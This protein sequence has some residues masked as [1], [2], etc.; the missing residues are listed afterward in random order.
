M[1]EGCQAGGLGQ[2]LQFM[3]EYNAKSP[4]Q[5]RK[6]FNSIVKT[7]YFLYLPIIYLCIKVTRFSSEKQYIRKI[8]K[9]GF[10][11]QWNPTFVYLLYNFCFS[12]TLLCDGA[13]R[14]ECP[15]GRGCD[16]SVP[17]TENSW[18]GF[19]RTSYKLSRNSV[20][21]SFLYFFTFNS[22]WT[23]LNTYWKSIYRLNIGWNWFIKKNIG[24]CNLNQEAY[25]LNAFQVR[26]EPAPR[27]VWSREDGQP[28]ELRAVTD[29][30]QNLHIYSALARSSYQRF[31]PFFW[32]G[33]FKLVLNCASRHFFKASA[34]PAI[35]TLSLNFI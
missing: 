15:R 31:P 18:L 1:V 34:L 8:I 12:E 20:R 33:R 14:R 21:K 28:L 13:G 24:W 6:R 17:G 22:F 30:E 9:V 4:K 19:P 29:R 10:F 2:L 23:T 7:I 16:A 35:F 5:G 27:L 3:R 32:T 25:W 11:F 26:G